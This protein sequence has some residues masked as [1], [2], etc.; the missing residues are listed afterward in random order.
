[1]PQWM[2]AMVQSNPGS[3]YHFITIDDNAP[4]GQQPHLL[5]KCVF[6]SFKPCIEGFKYCKS[7]L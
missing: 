4:H 2:A 6:L 1:L 7:V 5:F 3:C